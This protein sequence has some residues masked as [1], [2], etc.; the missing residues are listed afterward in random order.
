MDAL[1]AFSEKISGESRTPLH[2]VLKGFC[3]RS[4]VAGTGSVE[5]IGAAKL[6]ALGLRPMLEFSCLADLT[7]QPAWE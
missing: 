2:G 5:A 6:V 1:L 7:K 4:I 3:I